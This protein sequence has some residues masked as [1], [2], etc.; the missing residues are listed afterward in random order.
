MFK[1][2]LLNRKTSNLFLVFCVTL[3]D[4]L[5]F[6][7]IIPF[8]PLLFIDPEFSLFP[9]HM[10]F[11]L[12]YIALGALYASYPLAQVFSTPLL[13]HFSDR[14]GR[15][16][17]L[18]LSYI[19]NA[20]G[21]FI[22]SLSIL[23]SSV[24][25][26][27]LGN[28][29][30]GF[31]GANLST[32]NAI[33]SDQTE[34]QLKSK[35]FGLMNM[36]LGLS[37]ALG[38][39]LSGKLLQAFPIGG[40]LC[41]YLLLTASFISLLNFLSIRF[42]FEPSQAKPLSTESFFQ[43]NLKVFTGFRKEIK[44]LLVTLFLLVFGW[45]SFIKTFQVFLLKENS[46]SEVEIFNILSYY[47]LCTLLAQVTY[48]LFFHRLVRKKAFIESCLIVL[49]LSLFCLLFSKTDTTLFFL[50]TL[51]SFAYALINPAITFLVSELSLVDHHGK[52]M[53]FY[54]STTALAKITAPLLAGVL[55]MIDPAV[56]L[57]GSVAVIGLS[58]VSF[59]FYQ[60]K[61]QKTEAVLP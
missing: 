6:S 46:L 59:C 4:L 30:A 28:L 49:A 48:I 26:L 12:R 34:N 32:V 54:Q 1:A 5:S 56:S 16:T 3:C 45:Y 11:Q 51:F 38:P 17:I 43:W 8:M 29:I 44:A 42:L 19:G 27:F 36:L 50:V 10:P 33:I 41:F 22:S 37:F 18:Q 13:G 20:I 40:K 23:Y 53:G 14:Y 58:F 35:L 55:L 9:A 24:I 31:T 61:R 47:G 52:M 15:K 25:P 2:V 57:M 60:K 7:A 39:F 21:Y